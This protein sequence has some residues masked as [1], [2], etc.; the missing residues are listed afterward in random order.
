MP[1]DLKPGH[2]GEWQ[3]DRPN[4]EVQKGKC[5]DGKRRGPAV[6]VLSNKQASGALSFS[7]ICHST[8]AGL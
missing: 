1:G 3:Y 5:F 6:S 4:R 2:A 8:T 7:C